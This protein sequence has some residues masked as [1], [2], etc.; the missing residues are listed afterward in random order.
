M[1]FDTAAFVILVLGIFLIAERL[2]EDVPVFGQA[3]DRPTFLLDGFFSDGFFL[4][5]FFS[6][7]FLAIDSFLFVG[8]F[9]FDGFGEDAAETFFCVFVFAFGLGFVVLRLG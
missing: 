5:R 2:A 4:G 1:V 3:H 8:F 9:G 7:V 6:G